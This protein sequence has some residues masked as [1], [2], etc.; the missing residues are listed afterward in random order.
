MRTATALLIGCA[1]VAF[2][3]NAQ[4]L[5]ALPSAPLEAPLKPQKT[6]PAPVPAANKQTLGTAPSVA[7]VEATAKSAHPK[8]P[9]PSKVTQDFY[10]AVVSGNLELADILL[11]KGADIN[12]A[13]CDGP[14][15]LH[16]AL[17]DVI[18]MN[19]PRTI[20]P[21]QWLFDRK[22]SINV[23]A[24]PS[25]ETALELVIGLSL[26]YAKWGQLDDFY[27]LIRRLLDQGANPN[28]Q[29][30]RGW[31]AAHYAARFL[32]F[33]I[34]PKTSQFAIWTLRELGTAGAQFNRQNHEGN[35][36]LLGAVIPGMSGW[37]SCNEEIARTLLE[38]GA[39]PNLK[40]A[41]G[42]NAKTVAYDLAVNH[43]KEC[44]AL[45][46]LLDGGYSSIPVATNKA[47]QQQRS[48][49]IPPEL[50]GEYFGVLRMKT[51]SVMTVAV[52]GTL[53]ADG[54]VLLNAPRGI[55]TVGFV[56]KSDGASIDLRL[57]TRAPEGYK[58]ANG[59]RETESFDVADS[60]TDRIYR[61]SYVAPTDSGE[62]ILCP[63]AIANQ[64]QE[65]RPTL[66]ETLNATMGGLLGK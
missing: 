59:Q 17:N 8:V 39:D 65:C 46:K 61:G 44:N 63:Q 5:P 36:A 7:L 1:L 9:P 64:I 4:T 53:N 12:C 33:P 20:D 66:L 15:L 51:P 37:I 24:I 42:E 26:E 3:A 29:D 45:M 54:S 56:S 27:K 13:N 21:V 60:V 50:A 47:A 41:K 57:K 18:V 43:G 16:W 14:P 6:S 25:K 62:F 10:R 28:L 38:L 48:V 11:Q 40:N 19:H 22:A 2:E 34:T 23:Q 32:H 49:A 58:F 35:S 31:T 52:S 55:T 30:Q